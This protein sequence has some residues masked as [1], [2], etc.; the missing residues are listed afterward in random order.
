MAVRILSPRRPFTSA[1]S[2]SGAKAVLQGNHRGGRELLATLTPAW[3]VSRRPTSKA[4]CSIL[5]GQAR[6]HLG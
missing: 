4:R 2:A 5:E 1:S 3:Q 6:D